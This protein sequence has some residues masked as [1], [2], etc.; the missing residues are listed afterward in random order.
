MRASGV[1][2]GGPVEHRAPSG[3]RTRQLLVALIHES[4]PVTRSDLTRLSGLSRSAVATAVQRLVDDGLVTESATSSTGRGRPASLLRP[5]VA[6]GALVGID[7]GHDHVALAVADAHGQVLA[8]RREQVDVDAHSA[9]ALDAA[10]RLFDS[11]LRAAGVDRQAVRA[12]VAAIPGPLNAR[13]GLVQSATIL[14]SWVNMAPADLLTQRLQSPV[15]LGNDA[16][17]GALG[18]LSFGAGRGVA[19]LLYVKASHGIGAGLVLGGRLYQG[20]TGIAGEIGHTQIDGAGDQCRCGQ[21]GCLETMMSASVVRRR[22]EVSGFAV[23]ESAWGLAE[24]A[25]DP[26]GAR[27]IT[28]AGRYLGRVV[29]D[30]CNCLNPGRVVLGG[31]LGAAGEPF[32]VGVRESVTRYAQPAISAAVGIRPAELGLRAELMGTLARGMQLAAGW[33]GGR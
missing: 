29:A 16:E 7:F 32:A 5:R 19:D 9:E 17:L 24:V 4:A 15:H 33:T 25:R 2:N 8:E 10:V 26:I 14:S 12:V 30:I 20:A 11:E 3:L 28:E 18:E 27:V 21:R 22:L 13:S 6:D 31:Q 1:A 23:A